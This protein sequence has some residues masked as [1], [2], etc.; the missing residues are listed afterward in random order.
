[1]G[2]RTVLWSALATAFVLI[3]GVI[4]G[5]AVGQGVIGLLPGH[6]GDLNLA[7]AAIAVLVGLLPAGALWGWAISRITHAANGRRLAVAGGIGFAPTTVVVVLALTFFENLFVEQRQGPDLPIHNVFTMLFVPAAAIL[8]G[9]TAFALGGGA[10]TVP[11]AARLAV[12]GSRFLSSTSP[13]THSAGAWAHRGPSNERRCSRPRCWGIWQQ[14]SLGA[15]SSDGPS[16][17][18]ARMGHA[19]G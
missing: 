11:A 3:P 13:W 6:S 4:V 10:Q 5:V 15:P 18:A 12:A 17:G 2:A 9:L 7:L 1:M 16:L 8:A 19:F 14:R